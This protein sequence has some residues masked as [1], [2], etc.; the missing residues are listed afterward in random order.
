MGETVETLAVNLLA[1]QLHLN[2]VSMATKFKP[3]FKD[4]G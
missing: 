3:R 2:H 4:R 1:I